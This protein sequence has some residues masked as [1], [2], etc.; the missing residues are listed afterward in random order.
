MV[1]KWRNIKTIISQAEG[2]S[3]GK[4]KASPPPPKKKKKK[5]NTKIKNIY[6][7]KELYNIKKKH[8]QKEKKKKK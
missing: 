6:I 1:F 8:P 5:K 7:K 4:Y 2:K 3:L